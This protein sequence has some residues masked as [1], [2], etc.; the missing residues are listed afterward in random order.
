MANITISKEELI[1]LLRKAFDEGWYGSLELRDGATE[2]ILDDWQH[3]PAAQS[4]TDGVSIAADYVDES[5]YSV[6]YYDPYANTYH[7]RSSR[8]SWLGGVSNKK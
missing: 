1:V 8:D 3:R 4:S 2:R 5:K 6:K 7:Y